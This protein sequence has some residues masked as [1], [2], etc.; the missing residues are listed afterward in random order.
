MQ[1]PSSKFLL[2]LVVALLAMGIA[3]EAAPLLAQTP[4]DRAVELNAVAQPSPPTI[5]L[6]WNTTGYTVLAQKLYRRLKDGPTWIQIATPA[7]VATS[8]ADAAVALGVSYEYR[9]S[10]TLNGGPGTAEG[11]VSAGIRVPLQAERGRVILL[12]DNTMA[13]PL[14]SE[15]TRLESDLTG[16]GWIVVRQNVART[17]SPPSIRTTIQSIH[18]ADPANTAAVIL[19]GHIPVPYSGDF[20]IDGH[21]D[22]FGA[23]PTDVYYGDVD[24]TWT[25]TAVNDTSA[26]S[27]RND[28]LPGDGKFD[29]TVI[30]SDIE[31]Q[32]GRIDLADLPA[33][34][35][36]ETEL[37]RR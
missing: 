5:T 1:P 34:P 12:V 29:Q 13:A 2:H 16:D 21:P 3:F 24:G 14:A 26:S 8:Y 32:V 18:A 15:L 22:H 7:N 6:Q 20:A 35:V 33:F 28:N 25:D 30:P 4:R 19:F 10:R 27:P 36:S 37:L 31:L 11:Y 17:A 9:V 23:W